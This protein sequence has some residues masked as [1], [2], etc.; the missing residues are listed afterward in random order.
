MNKD[1]F[2]K[3]QRQNYLTKNFKNK[4]LNFKQIQIIF[5]LNFYKLFTKI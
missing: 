3:K 2:V 1:S 5:F 4:I